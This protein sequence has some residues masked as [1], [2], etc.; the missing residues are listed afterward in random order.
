MIIQINA[1]VCAAADHGEGGQVKIAG[2]G[3]REDGAKGQERGS[4]Q[5]KRR[6]QRAQQKCRFLLWP[7]LKARINGR[8]SAGPRGH[9]S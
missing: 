9:P 3:Q 5:A 4:Y 8:S 1:M 6:I 7:L 2:R